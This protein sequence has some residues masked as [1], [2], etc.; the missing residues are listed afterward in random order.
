MASAM[1]RGKS[2]TSRSVLYHH[3]SYMLTDF[4]QLLQ[5][6]NDKL[7]SQFKAVDFVKFLPLE[8]TQMIMHNLEFQTVV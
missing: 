6:A 5:S 4:I 1:F 8:L 7:A 3:T 2:Q